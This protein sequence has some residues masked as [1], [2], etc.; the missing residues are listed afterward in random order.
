[1]QDQHKITASILVYVA[2][3]AALFAP[4]STPTHGHECPY[5]DAMAVVMCDWNVNPHA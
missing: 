5:G 2:F 3:L 1:M 4:I